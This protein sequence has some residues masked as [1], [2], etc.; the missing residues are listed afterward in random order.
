MQNETTLVAQLDSLL[1]EE[2]AL[3]LNGKL[4]KLPELLDRKRTL[5][6]RLDSPPRTDLSDL[7]AKLTRNHAL[8]SSAMDGIRRVS[9]RLETLKQIH[10]S[11]ET[12]DSQGHRRSIGSP[13]TG[14][15][16]RRA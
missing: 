1:D 13:H 12:Y 9:E 10:R 11:L 2:R 14:R 4:D 3:L 8:L 5:V 15:M 7:H 16:E 6:E